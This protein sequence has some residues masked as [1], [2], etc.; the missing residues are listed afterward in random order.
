MHHNVT[1]VHKPHPLPTTKYVF[2]AFL[3]I[4]DG[5]ESGM[6]SGSFQTYAIDTDDL[7]C[8]QSG[9]K[10]THFDNLSYKFKVFF[11]AADVAENKPVVVSGIQS[12]SSET[13]A[14]DNDDLTCTTVEETDRPW[15]VVD[16]GME[17]KVHSLVILVSETAYTESTGT[18]AVGRNQ[19]DSGGKFWAIA[20]VTFSIRFCHPPCVEFEGSQPD[21]DIVVTGKLMVHI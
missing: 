17:T 20:S 3:F 16:L 10:Q 12:G 13:Y 15:L 7:T 18:V 21:F 8:T 11:F 2:R 9:K 1:E 19:F 5:Y 14:V 6:E 4:A